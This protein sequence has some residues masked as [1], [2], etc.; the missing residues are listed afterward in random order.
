MPKTKRSR[1]RPKDESKRTALLD[2]ARTLLL[3]T[4]PEVTTDNIASRAGVS[5]STLYANFADKKTMIEAVIRREADLTITDEEFASFSQE[6]LTPESLVS[7]G[8]RYVTFI[9]Q[10][11][12]AGWDRLIASIATEHPEFHKKIFELGPGRAQ[13]LLIQLLKQGMQQG[14]LAQVDADVAADVLTGLWL[15]FVNIEVKLGVRDPL[16]EHEVEKR[17]QRGVSIFLHVYGS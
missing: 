15:G 8:I 4:G 5:K 16:S 7:F 14:F 2:A 11:E 3:A 1:G 9:N 6:R 13:Q 10:R 12:L 17:V